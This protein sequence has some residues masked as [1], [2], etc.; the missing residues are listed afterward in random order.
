MGKGA[1]YEGGRSQNQTAAMTTRAYEKSATTTRV[2]AVASTSR[3][4]GDDA[5]DLTLV[6]GR[7]GGLP[8]DGTDLDRARVAERR[9]LE[10]QQV[11]VQE[12]LAREVAE[13]I[14]S[15]TAKALSAVRAAA[16]GGAAKTEGVPLR[17]G[18]EEAVAL[19]EERLTI[20]RAD[21]ETLRVE[22]ASKDSELEKMR[23]RFRNSRRG[24]AWSRRQARDHR[25]ELQGDYQGGPGRTRGSVEGAIKSRQA[26]GAIRG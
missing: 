1:Q 7:T 9:L 14:L 18:G 6:N 8:E 5:Y 19:L 13:A 4:M 2:D 15:E 12:R 20:L 21:Y 16:A 3:A 25:N 24:T 23:S 17:G 26:T 10:T 22:A 11:L